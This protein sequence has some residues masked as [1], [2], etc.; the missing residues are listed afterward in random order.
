[1]LCYRLQQ[2]AQEREM[3]EKIAASSKEKKLREH[4][5]EQEQRIAQVRETFTDIPSCTLDPSVLLL[6]NSHY[7]F[8]VCHF[9]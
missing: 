9:M 8:I 6:L 1:M 2:E 7:Y 4:Q 3:D 5:L